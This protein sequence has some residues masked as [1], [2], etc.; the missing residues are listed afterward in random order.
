MTQK[1]PR[2]T[3]ARDANRARVRTR[4]LDSAE[5]L[6]ADRGYFG[7]S[8]RD[9]TDH[10]GTRVAAISDY[11]QGKDNLFRHVLL[12][13]IQPINDDRR[14]LLAALPPTGS[15]DERLRALIHAFAH[16]MLARA[17]ENQGWRHYFR[18]IAQLANSGQSVQLLVAD[19]Y[20]SIADAF[21]ERLR[22]LFPEAGDTALHDAYLLMLA[23]TLQIFSNNLRLDS[24]TVGRIRT[25][26]LDQR[27]ASLVVFLEGGISRLASTRP[28]SPRDL[29]IIATSSPGLPYGSDRED[30]AEGEG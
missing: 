18:F 2:P 7:T 16:P 5:E 27:Y 24:L 4:L 26:D 9:I 14:A 21:I 15:R 25:D 17:D 3:G 10:A 6:F 19:E 23:S 13:R 20:N 22:H 30:E 29:G 1:Q 11:F 12:R 8:V 28:P